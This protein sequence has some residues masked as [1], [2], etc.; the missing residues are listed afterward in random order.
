MAA[1]GLA[2]LFRIPDFAPCTRGKDATNV[3]AHSTMKLR[4]R[5]IAISTVCMA[6]PAT[7]DWSQIGPWVVASAWAGTD[8]PGQSSES[9]ILRTESMSRAANRRNHINRLYDHLDGDFVSTTLRPLMLDQDANTSAS[10]GALAM[11]TDIAS[12][13]ESYSGRD[14]LGSLA[15]RVDFDSANGTFPTQKATSDR[16]MT[17]WMRGSRNTIDNRT[18]ADGYD[19]QLSGDVIQMDSGV[20][21][22]I[23]DATIAGISIGWGNTDSTNAER[24]VLYRENNVTFSPYFLTRLTEWLKLNG[25]L[26][27]GTSDITRTSTNGTYADTS[28]SKTYSASVGFSAQRNLANTPLSVSLDGNLISARE[29][30]DTFQNS[31]GETI[32][33]HFASSTLF[34]TKTEAKYK[35]AL[36][37]GQALS[38]FVGESQ[39]TSVLNEGFGDAQAR[40]YYTGANYSFS[41][42]NLDARVEA[43]REF[44]SDPDPWEGVNAEIRFSQDLPRGYGTVVPFLNT[45]RDTDAIKWGGGI[46]HY[47]PS[48]SGHLGLQVQQ[49][50]TFDTTDNNPMSGLLT[51][52]FNM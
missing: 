20:D 2:L 27:F 48:L 9:P 28:S 12:S 50:M 42:L 10:S 15:A 13:I 44:S 17:I 25:S 41:P 33:D 40:R 29:Y 43:F 34:H 4:W 18:T 5:L 23:D 24:Q 14:A 49:T 6:F 16:A 52:S 21:Y 1:L 31:L 51:L 19:P 45:E 35:L 30:Y 47:W 11:G 38:P 8:N 3:T 39:T 46:D 7:F 32:S 36:G 22:R 37:G 26:G